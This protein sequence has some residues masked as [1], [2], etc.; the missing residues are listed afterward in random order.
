MV[1]SSFGIVYWIGS[2]LFAAIWFRTF[3]D[4]RILLFVISVFY[5]GALGLIDD[6]EHLSNEKL[7]SRLRIAKGLNRRS[8]AL[9]PLLIA[10]PVFFYVTDH[11]ARGFLDLHNYLGVFLNVPPSAIYAILFAAVCTLSANIYNM[12][13]GLHG[14]ESCS[15]LT[16]LASLFVSSGFN[17]MLIGP[18]LVLV[19]LSIL[20]TTGKVFVSNVGTF[21]IGASL[22]A[23]GLTMQLELPL[24]ISFLPHTINSILILLSNYLYGDY[25]TDDTP[26]TGRNRTS[27]CVLLFVPSPEKSRTPRAWHSVT[28]PLKLTTRC[29]SLRTLVLSQRK[30]TTEKQVVGSILRYILL[31]SAV[32]AVVG[33]LVRS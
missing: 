31:S 32:A 2:I 22:G 7:R 18:L 10:L 20:N 3:S 33:I 5:A 30:Y 14:L 12:L 4:N 24:L 27:N 16:I 15:G 9:L 6:L 8:K 19:V 21:S 1:P 17:Q 28:I 29:R 26:W 11:D 25:D 23:L 13:G